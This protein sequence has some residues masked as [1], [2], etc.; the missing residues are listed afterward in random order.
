MRVAVLPVPELIDITIA[1][2]G[3]RGARMVQIDGANSVQSRIYQRFATD[4]RF[5]ATRCHIAVTGS[6]AFDFLSL[7]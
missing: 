5:A 6:Q 1:Q 4:G 2:Q 3:T 7:Y